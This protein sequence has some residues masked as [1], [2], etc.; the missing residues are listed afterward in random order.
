M[1]LLTDIIKLIVCLTA[2][3]G[4]GYLGS[5]YTTPA[6]DS[7]YAGLQKPSFNPPNWVF[8]PVW[9]VLYVLMAVAAFLIWRSAAPI[10]QKAPALAAFAVQL[11]LNLLWSVLFFG[12]RKPAYALLEIVVLWAMIIVTMVLF[13]RVSRVAALLLTPYLA[14]VTFAA[15]LNSELWRLNRPQ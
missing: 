14:W 8:M 11:G 9:T 1:R 15:V 4:V 3:L 6:I 10:A 2:T 12:L 7:W 5:L 13:N